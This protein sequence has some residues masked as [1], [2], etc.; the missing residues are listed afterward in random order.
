VLPFTVTRSVTS[1]EMSIALESRDAD[2]AFGK[3]ALEEGPQVSFD[4][5]SMQIVPSATRLSLGNALKTAEGPRH[6]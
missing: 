3:S 2:Y 5:P 6:C 4:V 1:Q